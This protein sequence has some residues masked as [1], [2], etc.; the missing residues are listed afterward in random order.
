VTGVV[1]R[2]TGVVGPVTGPCDLYSRRHVDPSPAR[3]SLPAVNA[4]F[5][6]WLLIV[7]L[8]G[9][10]GLV[11]LILGDW[12]RR[13]EEVGEAERARESEWIAESMRDEGAA[14]DP[15]T[16]EE[17]LRRHRVWLR[18]TG[19]YD[20]LDDEWA[21]TGIEPEPPAA[22]VAAPVAAPAAAP[23]VAPEARPDSSVRAPERTLRGEPPAPV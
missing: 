8:V 15:A 20:P 7:G 14:I 18:E 6:W 3:A 11:W 23:T 4:E 1:G 5:N 2:V 22:P 9:G 13:E 17:V 19:D 16:A 12:S 10:A 21:T